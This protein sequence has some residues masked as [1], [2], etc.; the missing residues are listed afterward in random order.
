MN[1]LIQNIDPSWHNIIIESFK[2][3]DK[4][5]Q[6]FLLKNEDFFPAIDKIFATFTLP[7]SQTKYIL[8]GQDPYPRIES[9]SGFAFIDSNVDSLWSANGLSKEVNKATSLRNLMKTFLL[10]NNYLSINNTSKEAIAKIDKSQFIDSMDELKNNFLKHGF[11]LLN[12]SLIF[13]DKKLSKHH[14]KMWQP[15]MRKFLSLVEDDDITLLLWGKIS[16]DINKLNFNCKRIYSEHPYNT[17]FITN[18]KNLEFFKK[19]N[20]LKK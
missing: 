1:R 2:S 12:S 8:F 11:L 7:K 17:S 3:L 15:F 14:A 6:E 13:E 4:N 10:A 5:Y 9:A 20:L 19:F 16:Q 18:E